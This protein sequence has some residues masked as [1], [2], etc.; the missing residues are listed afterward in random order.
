[1]SR[2]ASQVATG[3]VCLSASYSNKS[4]MAGILVLNSV[5]PACQHY[6]ISILTTIVAAEIK[7]V[8]SG[9]IVSHTCRDRELLLDVSAS[10]VAVM[11]KVD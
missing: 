7:F 2:S 4:S 11:K 3:W 5:E 1:M 8:G 9:Q 6:R 10:V